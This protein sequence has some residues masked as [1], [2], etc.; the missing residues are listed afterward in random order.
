MAIL[1]FQIG[2]IVTTSAQE[3][4]S[5]WRAE[6]LVAGSIARRTMKPSSVTP[7]GKGSEFEVDG[8][9]N[10]VS[11]LDG[12]PQEEHMCFRNVDHHEFEWQGR[13]T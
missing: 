8:K 5:V 2:E 4:S 11:A 13:P 12:V 3:A 6:E 10:L 7:P 1:L 9:K